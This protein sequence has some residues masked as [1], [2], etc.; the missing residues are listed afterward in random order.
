GND[1]TDD[2]VEAIKSGELAATVATPA[3]IQGFI[4]VHAALHHLDGGSVPETVS[5][6]S[7]IIDESNVDDAE[8]LLTAVDGEDRYW[9]AEF[10]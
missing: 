8:S 5:E 6:R 1:G 10:K 4:A 3:Y 9:E 7:T 2:A